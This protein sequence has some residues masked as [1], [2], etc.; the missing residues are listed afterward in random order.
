MVT[1]KDSGVDIAKN[2]Q[3]K[4]NIKALIRS[5]YNQSV[6]TDIGLFSGIYDLKNI[7]KQYHDPV[8]VHSIDGVGTKLKVA[9]M[10]KKYDTLGLDLVA[11]SCNDIL[12]QGARPITF[13]DYI[14][15]NKIKP[16][17]IKEIIA[18]L[19]QACKTNSISLIAGETAEMPDVYQKNEI[20][21]VGTIIGIVERAKMITGKNI[22]PGDVVL[23]FA[24]SGLHT[25]GYSLARKIIFKI[26]K[27]KI[28]D[29]LSGIGQIGRT[30]LK[31]HLNYSQPI[32]K[33]LN[34][35]KIKGIAHIT[36]GGLIDNPPRILPANTAL[37]LNKGSWPILPIFKYLQKIGQVPDFDM[38][39]TFNMGIGMIIVIEARISSLVSR[40]L[41]EFTW[42]K[43][44]KIGRIIKGHKKVFIK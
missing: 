36:G 15:A 37:E 22:I 18:G 27:K 30:L 20:D 34:K 8:L 29:E 35:I 1:Y 13:L 12:C 32:L 6:L 3:V 14:A 43:V 39:R 7:I 41:K 10:M 5:T 4:K 19:A 16:E 11:H 21:L 44:Y 25:N 9:T 38:Y 42:L 2:E 23:G 17:I 26:A 40:I 24:S 28:T 33:L 31:P